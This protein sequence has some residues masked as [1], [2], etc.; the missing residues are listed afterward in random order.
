MKRK[1]IIVEKKLAKKNDKKNSQ[2]DDS[3]TPLME[4]K[5]EHK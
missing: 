4:R 2:R 1:K 5:I 3:W